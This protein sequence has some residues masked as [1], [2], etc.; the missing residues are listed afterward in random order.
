MRVP[1]LEGIFPVL[2]TSHYRKTSDETRN[3]NCFAWAA[4][5]NTQRWDTPRPFHWPPGVPRN[6]L[7]TTF[8]AM[9]GGLGYEPCG[10]PNHEPGFE[11]VAFYTHN[12][13]V[14]HAARQLANGYW[15]SK[16]GDLEDIE[17]TLEGLQG[18]FHPHSYGMPTHFMRRALS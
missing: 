13:R 3:Y 10:T 2:I 16:C 14:L 11:K 9:F 4:G 17:H 8:Q 6:L 15:T 7:V 18:M 1:R 5:D 12:G